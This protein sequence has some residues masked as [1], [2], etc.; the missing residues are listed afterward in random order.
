MALAVSAVLL[1]A[2]CGLGGGSNNVIPVPGTPAGTYS[3]TVTGTIGSGSATLQRNFSLT[4][5][6]RWAIG[7]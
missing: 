3:L 6:V 1:W 2:A 7:H 4:L 5:T